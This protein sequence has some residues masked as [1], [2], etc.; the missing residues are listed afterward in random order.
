M[1]KHG[2]WVRAL[3]LMFVF[4]LCLPMQTFALDLSLMPNN[5]I[6]LGDDFFSMN[7]DAMQD[8]EATIPIASLLADGTNKNKG[9][10]KFGDLWYDTFSL[11][12]T[13]FLNPDY[14]MTYEQVYAIS[15]GSIW[16]KTGD[17]VISLTSRS[18]TGLPVISDINVYTGK[19]SIML[20]Q[21]VT[22][23]LGDLT[24]VEIPVAWDTGT[25]AYDK[26]TAGEYEFTGTPILP[27]DVTNPFEIKAKAKVIVNEQNT[28]GT[29]LYELESL[30]ELQQ[31]VSAAVYLDEN[32]S[33]YGNSSIN[34]IPQAP[35]EI[36]AD[37]SYYSVVANGISGLEPS[38]MENLEFSIYVPDVAQ[39]EYLL[40]KFYT[41][42]WHNVFYENGIGGW[43]LNNGW[44]KIRRTMSNFTYIN[45]TGTASANTVSADRAI[46]ADIDQSLP[47]E[48]QKM[49]ESIELLNR[50]I[51][52]EKKSSLLNSS[53]LK[54]MAASDTTEEIKAMEIFVVYNPAKSPNV[55]IDR[56]GYDTTGTPKI[57]FTF[58]DAWLDVITYGKPILDAKGF[59]ATTWVNKEAATEYAHDDTLESFWFMVETDL[60]SIYADGWD[61]GNHTFSHPDTIQDEATMIEEYLVNQ[62]WIIEKGWPRGAYHVCY[63]SGSYNDVLTGILT[64]IGVKTART[65]VHGIQP[66]PVPDM[67]KLKCVNVSRDTDMA[68]VKNEVDRA[69]A[70]G[71][72]LF[73]MLH[74]VEP[75]PE[76]DSVQADD[77]DYYG[78]LA[79]S[80][81]NLTEL[82]EY[83]DSYVQQNKVDVTTISQWYDTYMGM[84]P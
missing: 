30:S 13:Q 10:F 36:N 69:I 44:N 66:T 17:E 70:T 37:S 5:T 43:E 57:L 7:S 9:Y 1:K 28:M 52:S 48:W 22:A 62:Q 35:I 64:S 53:I 77:K 81:A 41:D 75:V 67:Y 50:Q 54:S 21:V 46:L 42:D 71:S 82:V 18:I 4:V 12:E 24:T 39:I 3:A 32:N 49:N 60:A 29:T 6:K 65:T 34:L 27:E 47:S 76:D 31:S 8:P 20:P 74:R 59:K 56:I 45:S 55:N 78:K 61:I 63:P 16:Y 73:F 72:S 33:L 2:K 11:D 26:Y 25:P 80:V 14:A 68:F 40:V 38:S 15:E 51:S 19:D 23:A 83:I 58:D 84:N 79:V